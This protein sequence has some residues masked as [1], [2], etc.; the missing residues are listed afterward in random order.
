M[1]T[2]LIN[3]ALSFVKD[4][5]YPVRSLDT[6]AV[7]APMYNEEQGARGC[8]ES[9][10]NQDSAPQEIVISINGGK[11]NTD[12]VVTK[13]LIDHLY[14]IEINKSLGQLGA[15]MTVW[16]HP[17]KESLVKLVSY[18][19]QIGK[20]ESVN[21]LINEQILNTDR[22]IVVDGDTILDPGFVR[23]IRDHFYRLSV[24]RGPQFIL[25]DYGMQSGA[26][27]SYAPEGS[28]PSQK[29]ISAGRK[30]EYAF[31]GVLKE[32]QAK[33]L[34]SSLLANSRLYTVVGCGFGARKDIFPV[35][36]DTK[37]EDH[38]LTLKSQNIAASLRQSSRAELEARGFRIVIAGVEHRPSE[39]LDAEDKVLIRRSG[40]VR[41]ANK[42]LMYT[43]DPP[44]LNGYVNQVERWNGGG[45]Q[46]ALKRLKGGLSANVKYAVW[47]SLIENLLGLL[48]LLMIPLGLAVHFGNPSIGI[49]PESV[50]LGLGIDIAAM[51]ILVAY[52]FYRYHRATG[53][54][55]LVAIF[56]ALA[57]S[58]TT[59]LP[60]TVLR[61]INPLTYLASATTVVP[62]FLRERNTKLSH[63]GAK[64]SWQR[65]G[66]K[67]KSRT[68]QIFLTTTVSTVI[69]MVAIFALAA[70]LSP[71]NQEAW[72]LIYETSDRLNIEQFTGS[73]LGGSAVNRN[74]TLVELRPSQ[75]VN[76]LL[77]ASASNNV[78]HI[79]AYCDPDFAS[80]TS[81]E[82][83][84]FSGDAS[85]Y[86]ALKMGDLLTLARLAPLLGLIENAALSYDLP[87]DLLIRILINESYLDPLAVG[88]TDDKGL[89]QMTSDALTMLKVLSQDSRGRFYNPLLF[90][91][92]FNV[93][94]PDFSICAGAAK[95]AWAL[96]QKEVDNEREA[97][98]LYINPI[99]G[100][101]NGSISERHAPLTEAIVNLIPATERIANVYAAYKDKPELLSATERSLIDISMA[102][103]DGG[104][105]LEQGY[106]EVYGIV[107]D[108]EIPDL[109]IYERL[110]S[111][112]YHAEHYAVR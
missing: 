75:D 43:Q 67:Q 18:Q 35:P 58:L 87:A 108:A 51:I 96:Q 110:F 82:A 40:N 37:T 64:S 38:D 53:R 46:N 13:T 90:Q 55:A 20:A 65:P 8:L 92:P 109:E 104:M 106:R 49:A 98:A 79:S 29:L 10:L 107:K 32:G 81:I 14:K 61:Y 91:E 17:D 1:P 54:S 21:N 30:A 73:L 28:S 71:V 11:D 60:F 68:Q 101:V 95:L 57:Q 63:Q 44:H 88:P 50:M 89:S 94:D 62:E 12:Q 45:Q 4:K 26:V 97:Y 66:A 77:M 39:L 112:Y 36:F 85:A 111:E 100:L 27:M 25:E 9:L 56:L 76:N 31:A 33:M 7:I 3:M 86:T 103:K 72:R 16:R 80:N 23:E 41:Y 19:R 24:R 105:V 74:Y 59:A 34:G 48:L 22:V 6:V 83:R 70:R 102:I 2:V 42:A 78:W 52:G 84:A 47:S 99:N 93:F 69:S 5:S 15:K